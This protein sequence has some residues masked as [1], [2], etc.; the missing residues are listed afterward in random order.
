MKKLLTILIYIGTQE[1]LTMLLIPNI[2][3]LL[4]VQ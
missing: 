3:L 1:D 4:K 2:Q